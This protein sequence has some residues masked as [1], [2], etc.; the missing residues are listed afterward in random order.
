[1]EAL[2]QKVL[3]NS[4]M[5]SK[6]THF[7]FSDNDLRALGESVILIIVCYRNLIS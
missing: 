7:I 3:D 5:P 6:L 2:V 1:M 4:T